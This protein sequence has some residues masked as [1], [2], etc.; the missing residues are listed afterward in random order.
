MEK[1]I[2]FAAMLSEKH[3]N[4][5]G[6]RAMPWVV[7]VVGRDENGRKATYFFFS[8]VTCSRSE[9]CSCNHLKCRI[10]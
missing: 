3:N 7:A 5:G 9:C 8:V 4:K 2:A 6:I 10:E 1:K